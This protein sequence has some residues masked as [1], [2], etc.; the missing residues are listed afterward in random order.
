MDR[1]FKGVWIPA[2]IFL[3]PQLNAVEKILWADINSFTASGDSNFYKSNKVLAEQYGVSER[4]ISNSITKLRKLDLV[5]AVYQG[6][7]TRTLLCKDV[8][9]CEAGSQI[10]RGR[11]EESARQGSKICEAGSQNLLHRIPKK[12][13]I[14][15]TIIE[16]EDLGWDSE[17]FKVAWLEWLKYR[18]ETNLKTS[19]T[20]L[21]ASITK[22][23]KISGGDESVA[24]EIINESIAN[25]WKG[26][27]PLKDRNNGKPRF[28][29]DGLSEFITQ[30]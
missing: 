6:G 11:V 29:T 25:G 15:N 19:P 4:T 30:G 21:K 27:F 14:E 2:P 12:N 24:I 28:T 18:R 3:H 1:K 20:G 26:F 17:R 13:T 8:H 9:G 16:Q 23:L 10:L 22:L 5:E 7:R